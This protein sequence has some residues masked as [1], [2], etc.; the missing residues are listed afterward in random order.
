MA[1]PRSLDMVVAVL[2]VLKAGAAYL[3]IDPDYPSARIAFMFDDAHPIC[4]ITT[5]ATVPPET[6]HGATGVDPRHS[7]HLAMPY[8]DAD[9]ADCRA[10]TAP[11]R[12]RRTPPT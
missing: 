9:A 3:P 6:D 4:L 1:L 7:E 5:T 12:R 11:H 2:A 10:R 8:L